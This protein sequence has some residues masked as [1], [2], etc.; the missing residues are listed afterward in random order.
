MENGRPHIVVAPRRTMAP[1][2][3]MVMLLESH[4]A[5]A[6]VDTDERREFMRL[7]NL[8]ETLEKAVSHGHRETLARA[9]GPLSLDADAL[10]LRQGAA[11][12]VE[13]EDRRMILLEDAERERPARRDHDAVFLR[14]VVV[15][16]RMV[17]APMMMLVVPAPGE[18][19]S[20]R[21]VHRE[22]EAGDGDRLADADRHRVDEAR[23]GLV[24][25]QERD[26]R[27]HDR[28]AEAGEVTQLAGA[29]SKARIMGVDAGEAV[30]ERRQQQ[31][32]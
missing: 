15:P 4:D 30:G 8:R 9:I 16:G 14:M 12:G 26:H 5:A 22:A 18:Q 21:D 2:A 27:E 25:D 6:A 32:A 1:G 3:R 7:R 28:A 20:T 29:E 11:L 13:P 24:A 10:R 31:G 19:P 17:M 23:D